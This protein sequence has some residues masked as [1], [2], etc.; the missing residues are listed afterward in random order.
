MI[1]WNI[2]TTD[3]RQ[4]FDYRKKNHLAVFCIERGCLPNTVYIDD[5]ESIYKTDKFKHEIW[6]KP[7]CEKEYKIITEYIQQIKT[8][9]IAVE[10]QNIRDISTMNINGFKQIV[11][12]PLQRRYDTS[13]TQYGGWVE[14]VENFYLIMKKISV[15]HKDIL[16][17][18][19]N[20][21]TEILLHRYKDQTINFRFVDKYHVNDLIK[22]CD[23]VIL[24]NSG[25]GIFSMMYNKPCGIL[26][27]S[28]YHIPDVNVK[29]NNYQD[30]ITF[31]ENKSITVNEDAALRYLYYLKFQYL[32]DAQQTKDISTNKKTVFKTNTVCFHTKHLDLMYKTTRLAINHVLFGPPC[33]VFD[34]ILS[35]IKQYMDN[36]KHI[37]SS[38]FDETCDIFIIWRLRKN[39]PVEF[40]TEWLDI[41]KIKNNSY[42]Y[43]HESIDS[44]A[45]ISGLSFDERKPLFTLFNKFICTSMKQYNILKNNLPNAQI[46]YSPLASINNIPRSPITNVRKTVGFIGYEYANDIKNFA[47]FK[48]IISNFDPTLIKLKIVT[49]G[50]KSEIDDLRHMKFEVQVSNNVTDIDILIITSKSE[51][52]PIPVYECLQNNVHCMSTCVGNVNEILHSKYIY[53]SKNEGIQ[54]L[55]DILNNIDNTNTFKN[56][57][58]TWE[59]TS[60]KLTEILNENIV[61][62]KINDPSSNLLFI[63]YGTINTKYSENIVDVCKYLTHHK[64]NY[65]IEST[66]NYCGWKNNT[67]MKAS[68]ILDIFMKFMV[69]H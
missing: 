11:F 4:I 22:L 43:L 66:P 5:N 45:C 2:D 67:Y 53:N 57:E 56:R 65:Y 25:V 24:I 60:N 40:K 55:H 27:E 19:K 42:I 13:I 26:G 18:I 6:N 7:L 30:I 50:Y 28:F 59:L 54:V 63:S 31:I 38:N 58:F 51:G 35:K 69:I 48:N 46:Y 37:V 32:Y 8:Q 44:T 21:P 64:Y 61:Y 3:N 62:F 41:P 9:Q 33:S 29:I 36:Y 47:L 20:H 68:W 10:I 49:N 17:L 23:K 12:C 14:S 39:S 15:Q 1:I 52:S 34:S 16:F